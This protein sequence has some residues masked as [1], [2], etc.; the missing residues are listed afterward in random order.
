V[1]GRDVASL[2]HRLLLP[3]AEAPSGFVPRG[4]V[5]CSCHDVAE[6]DVLEVMT[7]AADSP[8]MALE[9]AQQRLRCG[10]GCG[11]CLPELRRLARDACP[12]PA[13]R[14]DEVIQA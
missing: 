11:S 13:M 9:R 12:A 14:A 2:R 7:E 5:V 4:H 10:T 6:S 8:L 1:T 3:G